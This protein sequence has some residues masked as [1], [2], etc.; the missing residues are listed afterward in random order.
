MRTRIG[1][2]AAAAE[3]VAAIVI[4]V[5]VDRVGVELV[6]RARAANAGDHARVEGAEIGLLDLQ[7]RFGQ[8]TDLLRRLDFRDGIVGDDLM[9]GGRRMHVVGEQV[10][11]GGV[12]C[13]QRGGGAADRT[14]GRARRRDDVGEAVRRGVGDHLVEQAVDV[15]RDDIDVERPEPR[16]QR[17]IEQG[18]ERGKRRGGCGEPRRRL[19]DVRQ[20]EHHDRAR[21]RVAQARD[22]LQ[23]LRGRGG[24]IG[25]H[26]RRRDQ[27]GAGLVEVDEDVVGADPD[28]VEGMRIERRRHLQQL[29]DLGRQR[30]LRRARWRERRGHGDP[31]RHPA[32]SQLPPWL[33][34][35]TVTPKRDPDP[36]PRPGPD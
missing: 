14:R 16:L 30:P 6:Q 24:D 29:V 1:V 20:V 8:Q 36:A 5:V 15:D 2:A 27:A 21:T 35:V 9:P 4:A 12:R 18:R 33:T 3:V 23:R 34:G 22:L 7:R 19:A 32:R 31:L 10:G 25:L 26:L 17:R 13:D 28:R 11:L